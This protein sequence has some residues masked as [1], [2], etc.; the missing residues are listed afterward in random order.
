MKL[1][2]RGIAGIALII[3]LIS[4]LTGCQSGNKPT[5]NNGPYGFNPLDQ[6]R[7]TNSNTGGTGSTSPA[8]DRSTVILSPGDTIGVTFND[9]NP[10]PPAINDQIKED[11]S[12]TLYLSEKFQ[13]AGKTVRELQS[14]IHD[15]YV[16]KYYVRM[17]PSV[18]ISDRF[19]SV[20]GEVRAPNRYLW[21]PGMTVL[22]AIDASGGF[23]DFARKGKVLV[24]RANGKQQYQ[25]CIRALKH[26]ELDLS[27]YPGDQVLV[28]KRPF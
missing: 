18:L 6:S 4:S 13:A 15:R 7:D 5:A 25:D 19:F 17:T 2:G 20:G 8:Y 10:A 21:T 27:I 9:V 23:T 26:P 12:I 3:T 16:P 1:F 22:R 14:E 24:T 11:G 28:R